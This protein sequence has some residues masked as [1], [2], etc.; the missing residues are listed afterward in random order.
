MILVT[1]RKKIFSIFFSFIHPFYAKLL[2]SFDGEKTFV[3]VINEYALASQTSYEKLFEFTKKI[4]NNPKPYK[5]KVNGQFIILPVNLLVDKTSVKRYP[6]YNPN[7]FNCTTV[8]LVNKRLDFPLYITYMIN[9]KCY[10]DCIYCYADCRKRIKRQISFNRLKEIIQEATCYNAISFDIMGGEFFLDIQWREILSE[11]K[12]AHFSPIISTKM[13]ISAEDV[14]FLCGLGINSLQISLDSINPLII[15]KLLNVDGKRYL[16]EMSLTLKYLSEKGIFIRIN[17]V[18]TSFNT[19]LKEI[20]SLLD[21]LSSY[22]VREV[23]LTPAG[24]SLYKN[25]SNFMPSKE[26]L[27]LLER[28]IKQEKYPYKISISSYPER[29]EFYN[30]FDE[31]QKK[32]SDRPL[33]TGNLRQLYILPNGDVTICEGMMFN[34]AFVMGNVINSSI[35]EIWDS[36]RLSYLTKKTN[37][38]N[39]VCGSCSE[40]ESCHNERGVCWKLAIEAYGEENYFYPDPRCP[41]A[42]PVYNKIFIE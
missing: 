29:S 40:F 23:N 35:K 31:K 14:D 37:F 32:Y 2:A 12:K 16:A 7:S 10:T 24:N 22:N 3:E 25:D 18:I 8:D 27:V 1:P 21:F 28:E 15:Q 13:P 20:I 33:C 34:K 11:L 41:K 38:G 4:V 39:S 9:T 26:N 5:V 6:I 36:N 30:C 17:S 19:D 42:P